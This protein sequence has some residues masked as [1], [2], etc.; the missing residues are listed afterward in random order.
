MKI[1]TLFL[2]FLI[3]NVTGCDFPRVDIPDTPAPP[4]DSGDP[5]AEQ[6]SDIEYKA[7]RGRR[8]RLKQLNCQNI[9]EEE[10][11]SKCQAM[12]HRLFPR[13][14]R[15]DCYLLKKDLVREFKKI[16]ADVKKG[17]TDKLNQ[18]AL[19]C[20]LEVDTWPFIQSIKAMS[21]GEAKAFLSEIARD[22]D[23]SEILKSAD[24]KFKIIKQLLREASKSQNLIENLNTVVD[25]EEDQSFLWLSADKHNQPAFKW[26]ESYVKKQCSKSQI[27]C[28]GF[29]QTGIIGAYC[30][31][32]LKMDD[33]SGFLSS[34]DLFEQ[35][36]KKQVERKGYEY[37]VTNNDYTWYED[38]KGDFKD[39]CRMETQITDRE[40]AFRKKQ[41][42]LKYFGSK[43]CK[44]NLQPLDL[45]ARPPA[46]SHATRDTFITT[47]WESFASHR[48]MWGFGNLFGSYKL[49]GVGDLLWYLD[50]NQKIITHKLHTEFDI[51]LKRGQ[52]LAPPME[53]PLKDPKVEKVRRAVFWFYVLDPD[54]NNRYV[55]PAFPECLGG[56]SADRSTCPYSYCLLDY[57]L[58]ADKSVKACEVIKCALDRP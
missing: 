49:K 57:A 56:Y 22:P 46:T 21:A 3:L 12:C 6:G 40:W 11:G 43:E 37:R 18:P 23:L 32:L 55:D 5:E 31:A 17:Q 45:L 13:S 36:Y 51:F 53:S 48:L 34:A 58:N 15:E 2:L 42:Q 26:I 33:L 28:P 39:F 38:L 24:R 30:Q 9:G 20:L 29:D 19:H 8:G 47:H 16:V 50:K 7:Q 35:K 1:F 41:N 27:H 14:T 54:P 4:S 10:C 25:L 52:V 44:Q